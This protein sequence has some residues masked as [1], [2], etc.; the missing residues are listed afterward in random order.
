M[1]K[2]YRVTK[3]VYKV[4]DFITF[5]K[6][7]N[8][9][10]SPYF[11]R[12]SVWSK[13]AK[14]YL[15]D[16]IIRGLPIPII[17]LRERKA[18]L[19]S[20]ELKREVVDGQQRIRTV[21]S[22]VIPNLL[23]DF[24][25]GRDEFV[26]S[27]SHNKELANKKFSELDDDIKQRIVDYEFSVH[28]FPSGTDDREILEMFTRMNSTS[29]AL[30]PQELRNAKYFGEF[31]SST[32]ALAAGQ[33]F[34]WRSW[35]VFSEDSIARMNEVEFTS[36][37]VYFMFNGISTKRKKGLDNIYEEKDQQYKERTEV[38]RRFQRVMD[39]IDDITG[40]NMQFSRRMV[41]FL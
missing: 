20:L 28:V 24:N 35:K 10:L 25:A 15:I 17:F 7:N 11:Q 22:Y 40:N 19:R 23:E 21:I 13:G 31:K 18:D 26:I 37:L 9:I 34:R 1:I 27:K 32:Y 5:M 4:S 38:E 41:I 8:L 30:N 39:S 16:T 6:S 36:E 29:Y 14:S 3:T 33:L 12:R 2:P